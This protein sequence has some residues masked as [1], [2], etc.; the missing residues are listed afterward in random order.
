MPRGI[1]LHPKL[2]EA[3]KKKISEQRKKEWKNGRLG[4]FQKGCVSYNKG[5]KLSEEHKRKIGE[6]NSIALTGKKLSEATK[7]KLSLAM[8]G[9]K[10]SLGYKQ[11]KETIEK[12]VVHFRGEKSY[13]WKGGI[14]F[15][16]YTLDWTETLKRAIRQRD[17]YTCQICGK[18]PAVF[19]H[20]KDY[21]KK[22][23]NPDNLITLCNSC[24]GKTNNNRNRW[25]EYFSGAKKI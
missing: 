10:S 22:N 17:K 24:H 15:Q 23:C 5:K 12:R 2:S 13:W 4:G 8:M 19:V 18:E 9:N 6:S 7:G 3:H 11:S 16:P 20:H 21:D 1:F 25:I 14:S